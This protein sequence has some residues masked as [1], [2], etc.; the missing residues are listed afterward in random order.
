MLYI[1]SKIQNLV[2]N[3]AILYILCIYA[4]VLASILNFVQS[5]ALT[6]V[7]WNTSILISIFC[8]IVL[9]IIRLG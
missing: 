9:A 7:N 5:A 2:S 3:T 6:E 1:S 4:S 8:F